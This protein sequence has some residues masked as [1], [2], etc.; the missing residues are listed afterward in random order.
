MSLHHKPL[1]NHYKALRGGT[2]CCFVFQCLLLV[3]SALQSF[4]GFPLVPGGVNPRP[5]TCWG[6]RRAMYLP[7][8]ICSWETWPAN[9]DTSLITAKGALEKRRNSREINELNRIMPCPE[10]SCMLERAGLKPWWVRYPLQPL[11]QD[12]V[13]LWQLYMH[14]PDEKNK[15]IWELQDEFPTQI[16]SLDPLKLINLLTQDC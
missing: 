8:V 13:S 12:H 14:S 2:L 15:L 7:S 6:C 3:F 4:G 5:C 11:G 1:E 10:L 16:S 9:T